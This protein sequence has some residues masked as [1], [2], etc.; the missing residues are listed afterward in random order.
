MMGLLIAIAV[1][2]LCGLGAGYFIFS[3]PRGCRHNYIF[4]DE[5]GARERC[6]AWD[7]PADSVDDWGRR[8]WRIANGKWVL[9]SDVMKREDLICPKCKDLKPY[10]T[11]LLE[12]RERVK[13]MQ[14]EMIEKLI[15]EDKS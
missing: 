11:N 3:P 8:I 13:L 1:S 2:S 15:G 14:P 10:R 9:V 7:A 6:G 5:A 4:L 12:G